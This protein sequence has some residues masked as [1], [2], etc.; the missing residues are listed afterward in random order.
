MSIVFLGAISSERG[1]LG[2]FFHETSG[3]GTKKRKEPKCPIAE[4]GTGRASVLTSHSSRWVLN[5][6][7]AN[8]SPNEKLWDSVPLAGPEA[9]GTLSLPGAATFHS[10]R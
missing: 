10:F 7:S 5:F 8:L 4:P 6:S 3:I 9:R 1:R 2:W